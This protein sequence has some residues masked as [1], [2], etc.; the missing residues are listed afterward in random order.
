MARGRLNDLL[1]DAMGPINEPSEFSAIRAFR[2]MERVIR[3]SE[4]K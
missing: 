3:V 4:D 1:G 2:V